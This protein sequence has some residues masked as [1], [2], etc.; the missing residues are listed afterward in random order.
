MV[1]AAGLCNEEVAEPAF[2]HGGDHDRPARVALEVPQCDETDAEEKRRKVESFA[3]RLYEDGGQ[4]VNMISKLF[5]KET[6]KRVIL[7][8]MYGV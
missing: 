8:H 6:A 1:S 7:R 3:T 5:G 2:D 4:A